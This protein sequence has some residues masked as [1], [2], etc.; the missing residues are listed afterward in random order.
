MPW[1]KSFYFYCLIVALLVGLVFFPGLSGGFV[2]DD[3]FNILQN[4]LL[5]VNSFVADDLIN[6]ALSF[7]DGNGSRPLPMMSFALDYWRQGG[8]DPRGFKVTNLIIHGVT[9]F[10]M[11]LFLRRLLLVANWEMS[12]ADRGALCLALVWAI[13]PIQVSSVMYVVQRMQTME[14]LFLVLSLWAYLGMRQMQMAGA[15]RGRG[16]GLLV[17]LFW[18]LALGCK[19]DAPALFLFLLALELTVLR[20]KAADEKVEKGLRQ[21]FLLLTVFGCIIYLFVVVPY[22]WSWD[23]HANRNFSTPGRLLTQARVLVMY[24]GQIL[25][26]HP[27][28]MVFIYD[29]LSVSHSFIQP[30][31]TLPSLIVICAILIWAWRWR[32]R[33]PLFSLGVLFFFCGHFI[34]SN[35][36]PLELAFEHRNHFPLIGVVISISDLL[37][38]FWRRWKVRNQPRYAI[39]SAIILLL[40]IATV[41]HAYTWGDPVRH[42][43]KLTSLLPDSSRA[44][45]QLGGAHFDRYNLTK[46]P[47]HLQYAIESNMAGLVYV[48]SPSLAANVVIYKSI[49]GAATDE[50]WR[51]LLDALGSAS[52]GWQNKSVV[53]SL[54]NNLDRGFDL[55]KER[56]LDVVR[57]LPSKTWLSDS[58]CLRIAIFIYKYGERNEALPF[59][60][61]FAKKSPPEKSTLNRIIKELS[62]AGHESWADQLR[63]EQ[64]AN[65]ARSMQ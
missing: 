23:V 5:Y 61:E 41:I 6:A 13:H 43:N 49:Q 2:L 48:N 19:E 38:C 44:W 4:S 54:L 8:M 17:L 31:T 24:L 30:W 65:A 12:Q 16:Y 46:D 42:G 34:T 27:D 58:E 26:P 22:Y 18:L 33:R 59:F 15:G 50:D 7:H 47:T 35:V 55:N 21:S 53:W 64:A 63:L 25:F 3:G 56:L 28:R 62:E 45:A 32:S 11:A 57:L 37:F 14:T 1:L 20:F 10:F 52:Y 51:R 9:T 60:I 36:I 40:G 39:I 29:H